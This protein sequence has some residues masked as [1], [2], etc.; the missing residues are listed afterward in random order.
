MSVMLFNFPGLFLG[1]TA[2]AIAFALRYAWGGAASYTLA[3]TACFCV[4]FD[5]AFRYFRGN[6]RLL[7]PQS[8]GCIVYLPLWIIGILWLGLAVYQTYVGPVPAVSSA[9][10]LRR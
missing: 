6:R 1:I 7:H 2:F 5:L 10:T 3:L 8:G 9:A 4:L